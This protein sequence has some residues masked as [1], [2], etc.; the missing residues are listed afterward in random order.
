M[1]QK[2]EEIKPCEPKFIETC[3]N[4]MLPFS[5]ADFDKV[6]KIDKHFFSDIKQYYIY[7]INFSKNS[8]LEYIDNNSFSSLNLYSINLPGDLLVLF[9]ETLKG[10]DCLRQINFIKNSNNYSHF[11]IICDEAFKDTKI[12]SLVLPDNIQ[13]I[14]S[15]CFPECF[16]QIEFEKGAPK[17]HKIGNFCFYNTQIK[18]F[19]MPLNILPF[20][21][22]KKCFS[23]CQ[24]LNTINF[25]YYV[26]ENTPFKNFAEEE[27]ME[28]KE[29]RLN[30][31]NKFKDQIQKLRTYNEKVAENEKDVFQISQD[32]ARCFMLSQINIKKI[33][34]LSSNL[35][36]FYFFNT[37]NLISIEIPKSD[38]A[39]LIKENGC[40]YSKDMKKLIVAERNIKNV[41]ICSCTK[42]IGRSCFKKCQQ[43]IELTFSDDLKNCIIDKKA[44]FMSG[45]NQLYI[46]QGIKRLKSSCFERCSNLNELNFSDRESITEIEENVFKCTGI[47]SVNIPSY[48]TLI[49]NYSFQACK[50]L[51][52][53]TINSKYLHPLTEIYSTAFYECFNLER[54]ESETNLSIIIKTSNNDFY[55]NS[56]IEIPNTEIN[57]SFIKDIL[58]NNNIIFECFVTINNKIFT[59]IKDNQIINYRFE[60]AFSK[61]VE[62][63]PIE[64]IDDV[65]YS[66]FR[67][68][69][70]GCDIS[71]ESLNVLNETLFI[72]S[73]AFRYSNLKKIDF[74][75]GSKLKEIGKYA[76]SNLQI[77]YISIPNSVVKID[78]SA[79]QDCRLLKHVNFTLKSQLNSIGKSAFEK[80][81]I[82]IILFPST[83]ESIGEYA[84]F[85]CSKLKTVHNFSKKIY[86]GMKSFSHSA[87]EKII[88][89]PKAV[90]SES[91]FEGC[92]ELK[93]IKFNEKPID[94]VFES[95]SFGF[96]GLES[97]HIEDNNGNIVF[98]DNVFSF[99]P[100]LKKVFLNLRIYG[101]FVDCIKFSPNIETV[102]IKLVKASW[103]LYDYEDIIKFIKSTKI[104]KLD[105]DITYSKADSNLNIH[106]EHNSYVYKNELCYAN[107]ID[108]KSLFINDN[109]N[110]TLIVPSMAKKLNYFNAVPFIKK[111][112]WSQNCIVDDLGEP[113]FF[114]YYYLVE[115][116][117]PKFV[118][119][120]SP[121]LFE[122]CHYLKTVEFENGSQLI[123]IGEYAF[124]NTRVDQVMLPETVQIIR[125][126]AFSYNNDL[127]AVSFKG[128][129]IEN[130]AFLQTGLIEFNLSDNTKTIGSGAFQFCRSLSSFN[131]NI[132]QSNLSEIGQYA[133]AETSITEINIPPKVE[134]IHKFTFNGCSLLKEVKISNDSK[135]I[136][137]DDNSFSGDLSLEKI[138]IPRSVSILS[139]T[140][141]INT[142]SLI[143]IMTESNDYFDVLKNN[144]IYSKDHKNL[145]FVPRNLKQFE[146]NKGCSVVQSGAFCGPNLEKISFAD[147][148][149]ICFEKW[150]FAHSTALKKIVIPNSLETIEN[151]AFYGCQSLE[152]V[153]FVPNCQL[154]EIPKFCFAFSGLKKIDL[155]DSIEIINGSSFYMC[156]NLQKVNLPKV[157]YI[158][159]SAFSETNIEEIKF[160]AS[161]QFIDNHAFENTKSL[162]IADFSQCKNIENW[163]IPRNLRFRE[164]KAR[165]NASFNQNKNDSE[166]ICYVHE[167]SF[168]G[169]NVKTLKF[170]LTKYRWFQFFDKCTKIENYIVNKSIH[171]HMNKL[172]SK[173]TLRSSYE[174]AKLDWINEESFI[175]FRYLNTSKLEK[176]LL[177]D[178]IKIS[179]IP[180]CLFAF[181]CLEEIS[182]PSS[183]KSL[184]TS[185]FKDCYNLEKVTFSSNCQIKRIER[186]AFYG[187][188]R[189]KSFSIPNKVNVIS[190]K[191]FAFTGL[192]EIEFPSSIQKVDYMAFY[193]CTNLSKIMF[194][195]GLKEISDSS[196]ANNYSL[197]V[198]NLPN[199]LTTIKS[200]AFYNCLNLHIVNTTSQT[201]LNTIEQGAFENTKIE[202][203]KLNP[204]IDFHLEQQDAPYLN[205]IA[206]H[207]GDLIH[208]RKLEDGTIYDLSGKLI[209]VPKNLEYLKIDS[210]CESLAKNVLRGAKKLTT[211]E[212]LNK[213]PIE[214]SQIFEHNSNNNVKNMKFMNYFYIEGIFKSL[215]SLECMP[216][217][218][219]NYIRTFSSCERLQK[220][221]IPCKCYAISKGAFKNCINLK[222]VEFTPYVKSSSIEYLDIENEAFYNCC[223][224]SSIL[225]PASINKIGVRAFMNC[226][227]LKRVE[228]GYNKML[229]N[230][231]MIIHY[232]TNNSIN[233]K[234]IENEAFKN[235]N[236]LESFSIPCFCDKVGSSTFMNC[237]NLRSIKYYCKDTQT[238]RF[239]TFKNCTS[240]TYFDFKVDYGEKSKF[241]IESESF[242][243]CSALKKIN[244]EANY[245]PGNL[246][247][248][249]TKK[250]PNYCFYSRQK[251][252]KKA[253]CN[254]K[255]L[256][257]A[258]FFIPS[259]DAIGEKAF[260]NCSSLKSL[261]I[262]SGYYSLMLNKNFDSTA[263]IGVPD[264]FNI[265]LFR[266]QKI[267]KIFQNV[268]K[269]KINQLDGDDEINHQNEDDK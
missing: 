106:L 84:F 99:C 7:E 227:K 219:S 197:E 50:K 23:K 49:G 39:Q 231:K 194:N 9:P 269:N 122:N 240:L 114:S 198:I 116:T 173:S 182:I 184:K 253:F 212:F 192:T 18:S 221:V 66:N 189:L 186:F 150:A 46:P 125:Q 24:N 132:E 5:Q 171:L 54:F 44:F 115:I 2:D 157:R 123:E 213:K 127:K 41:Y 266:K 48:I 169:S 234:S 206:F 32:L 119:K 267:V 112:Q 222:T 85:E 144:E 226:T 3:S 21:Q 113:G 19:N 175:P 230:N 77:E 130:D 140:A 223:S 13:E 156:Q 100:N 210:Q 233:L 191:S 205:N 62:Y 249:N 159:D 104:S 58:V 57:Q 252:H 154:K 214:K 121:H 162:K 188:R 137:I 134:V 242:M 78:D 193:N 164:Y 86:F 97:I 98:H 133:F 218:T 209:F 185:S 239:R 208:V 36:Y 167:S 93:T 236:S 53:V 70:V 95:F 179:N 22:A 258:R 52:N 255:S 103:P 254:C 129:I 262:N 110:D 10:C 28:E 55:N 170:D 174:I 256:V 268:V 20:V 27:E 265:K 142:P 246:F 139:H 178:D 40:L 204:E 232:N 107:L 225:I 92:M 118:T 1:E 59:K 29:E 102:E 149:L 238:I 176:I 158:G 201:K 88:F 65:Y 155:P 16:K 165:L 196:F 211:I 200:S 263:F 8:N 47:E 12:E 224:L 153:E 229:S 91:S 26:N 4:V 87:I 61:Y 34:V 220:V 35:N 80:T 131:I 215:E 136:K 68:N 15:K 141:F 72:Y 43:L 203:L 6:E 96:S 247:D 245:L 261:E 79:F 199:S 217:S 42:I 257:S 180:N 190:M 75:I 135:L 138:N 126:S 64:F 73:E 51:R 235:C 151:E 31:K 108:N 152:E 128:E 14:G 69:I 148:S 67:E 94:V 74:E 216:N 37:P 248:V 161:L 228:F 147:N 76:F 83:L 244:I 56:L 101:D 124:S 145:I 11:E 183:V 109:I 105:F 146:I 33:T 81:A 250:L 60:N 187:C 163:N 45:I 168:S 63:K 264:D 71:V 17:L 25:D 241:A 117:I 195:E 82:E 89:P 166:L 172:P 177:T 207:E 30:R 111:I 90:F 237:T 259:L 38:N 243:N 120:I 260:M 181:S 251:I 202:E 160:P 143:S